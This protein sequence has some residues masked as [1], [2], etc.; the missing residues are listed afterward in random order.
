[1]KCTRRQLLVGFFGLAASGVGLR[2]ALRG[3][4]AATAAAARVAL[5]FPPQ[6]TKTLLA[7]FEQALPGAVD[8]GVQDHIAWWLTKD[9]YFSGFAKEFQE[10]A[11]YLDHVAN[12]LHKK[13]FVECTGEQKDAVFKQFQSGGFR[14]QGFEGARFFEHLVTFTLEGY[15]G[16]PRYGGNRDQVGW[17]FIGFKPCWWAPRAATGAAEA[18]EMDH[19]HMDHHH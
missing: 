12:L 11:G 15:L 6:E 10:G 8:A 19:D 1:M 16:D 2:F 3:R 14:A 7:A 17:K 13:T 18:A 5:P 9:R 4:S